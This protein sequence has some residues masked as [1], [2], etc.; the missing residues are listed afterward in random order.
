MIAHNFSA[1]WS[2][3]APTLGNHLWQSTVFAGV[4]ALLTLALRKNRAQ[5]RYW[6]WLM[7]SMK[8]LVPFSLLA[9]V[10]SRLAWTRDAAGSKTGLYFAMEQV[11]QPFTR[12]AAI[13]PTIPPTTFSTAYSI[14]VHLLPAFLAAVW[15]A[16]SLLVLLVWCARWRGISKAIWGAAPLHEGREVE[17][18]RRQER[19]VGTRKKVQMLLTRSALEPGIFG[20]ARPVL[21]WPQGI[22]ARL[23]DEHLRAILSHELCH[24]RRRDNLAAAL[25]MIVEAIFWFHPLVWWL[26]TRLVEERERACDEEVLEM[27][28][29]RHVYAESVLKVCE[30]CVASPLACITGV[31]GSDLEKRMVHIMS[32]QM[33]RKLD[34]SKKL[35]LSTAGALALALP[36]VFG[37]MSAPRSKAESQTENAAAVTPAYRVISIRLNQSEGKILQSRV[38]FTTGEINLTGVTLRALIHFAYGVGDHQISGGPNWLN[39][40]RYDIEAKTDKAVADEMRNLSAVQRKIA[41]QRMLQGLLA[42]QFKLRLHSE[43]K[44]LPEYALVVAENGPKLSPAPAKGGLN[45]M[46]PGKLTANGAAISFLAEQLSWQPG[47]NRTVLDET[48]LKG[49]YNFTLQ[50]NP[51]ENQAG[52]SSVSPFESSGTSIFAALQEQLGLKLKPRSGPVQVLV[53]DHAEQPVEN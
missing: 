35:L 22:S 50:W 47:I 7:A 39:S 23:E 19:V 26:G 8:F 30:F 6:L 46:G 12:P 29:E 45:H 27:G 51:D 40:A 43:T 44:E 32:E 1:M 33:G 24:V 42:E 31:T 9:V 14:L 38:L 25:H 28:G 15:L 41:D 2:A 34:F 5:A 21:L 52:N 20:I 49:H 3:I 36:I 10:G 18:L 13:M 37:L 17:A 4:A 53:I 11:S 16:G 48:G